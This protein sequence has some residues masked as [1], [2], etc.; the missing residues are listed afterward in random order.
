MADDLENLQSARAGNVIQ[1][2]E[3][4]EKTEFIPHYME[5]AFGCERQVFADG[6]MPEVGDT[7]EMVCYHST[8]HLAFH[9]LKFMYK[10][11]KKQ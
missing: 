6:I 11:V 7:V 9:A 4:R 1:L 2:P 10:T 8:N 5:I 3:K